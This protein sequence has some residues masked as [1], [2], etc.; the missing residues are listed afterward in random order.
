MTTGEVLQ[1]AIEEM[2]TSLQ[3]RIGAAD[4]SDGLNDSGQ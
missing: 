3:D 1:E 4:G 2:I